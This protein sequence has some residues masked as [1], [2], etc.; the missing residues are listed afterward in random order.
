MRGRIRRLVV[1][2]AVTGLLAAGAAGATMELAHADT[3]VTS[4]DGFQSATSTAYKC[5]LSTGSATAISDPSAITV[6]VTDDTSGYTETVGINYT[7]NCTDTT[8]GELQTASAPAEQT[9]VTLNLSLPA[10]ADGTCNVSATVTSPSTSST[11]CPTPT[12]NVGPSPS[13]SPSAS[14]CPDDFSATLSYTPASAAS[15]SPSATSTTSSVHPVKGFD[16]KCLDDKGN[17]SS[18]RAEVVIWSCSGSDQAE[19]WQYSSSEFKHNGKCL[20]DQGN[21]GI[22]SKVILWSCDGAANEKWSELANGEIR[23]QSHSNKLCLDDPGYSTKN[24]TQLIVYTCKVSS[25]QK[26]SLP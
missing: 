4:C 20:N 11:D 18:N 15:P 10:S 22:R 1:C 21:G 19:N 5:T 25:N 6:G 24:G 9:P 7:V 13:P 3:P 26:W 16:G 23:L 8:N 2:G 14:V 17:S 12:G